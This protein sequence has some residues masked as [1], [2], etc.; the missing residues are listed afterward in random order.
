[1]PIAPQQVGIPGELL[2]PYS[3]DFFTI[4]VKPGLER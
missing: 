2:H 1:M 4:D 3:R